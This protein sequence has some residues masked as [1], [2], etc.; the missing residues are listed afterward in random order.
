MAD[1][2][3]IK[4]ATDIFDDEKILMIESLPNS[5]S[6]IVIW[7]KLLTFAGKQNNHGVFIM[8]DRIAYTED[9]LAAIFRRDLN[10]VRM[11]LKTF[12]QYGMIE[13]VEGTLTIP[14]WSKHQ[15]LDKIEKRNEYHKQYMKEYREKQKLIACKVNGEV[16]SEVNSGVN[17]N[18][19]EKELEEEL[20]KE[21]EEESN[22][23]PP[24]GDCTAKAV[25]IDY[26]LILDSWNELNLSHLTKISASSTRQR[27]VKARV[28]EHGID[29]FI[30]AIRNI[31][32]SSFLKGKNDRGWVIT[33]DWFIKPSNFI[34]V[35]EG[36]YN[37]RD[38]EDGDYGTGSKQSN[39]PNNG[40][41][42]D[43]ITRALG[44]RKIDLTDTDCD[45]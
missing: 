30:T 32:K 20:E 16:N 42:E 8:N 25:P 44:G 3:W 5:D 31:S 21:L 28:R 45:F 7:F 35:L 22:N 9:M 17:V 18:T 40:Q 38:K 43:D 27:M 39:Q 29:S 23:K 13:I 34:K 24:N 37:D 6:I 1:V 26:T 10:L 19:L 4:I 15:T 11:A 2:K 36:N 14:N 41:Y 12:E 33:F